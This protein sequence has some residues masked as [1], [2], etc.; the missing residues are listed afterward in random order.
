MIPR[1]IAVA[2]L[3]GAAG[4]TIA[5]QP[6]QP[7]DCSDWVPVQPSTVCVAIIPF[8]CTGALQFCQAAGT[9]TISDNDGFLLALR[10]I[11]TGSACGAETVRRVQLV[12][13]LDGI[14]EVAGYFEERCTDAPTS[15]MDRIITESAD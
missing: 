2:A 10:T 8:P 9:K 6:G 4:N 1:A 7:L 13:L 15:R 14:E 12:R 11:D 3:L 5:S